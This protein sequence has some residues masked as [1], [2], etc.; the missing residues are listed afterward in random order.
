[1]IQCLN[2]GI[3]MSELINFRDFGGYP[4]KDGRK[5]KTGIFYRSGS[6]RD[7]TEEDRAYVKT[8]NIQNLHDFREP[9]ELDKDERKEGLA[10]NVHDI[11]ASLHL[12]GF[13]EDPSV[14]YT[15]L[16]SES[17]IEFYE[18]LPFS[19]PAYQNVFKVLQEEDAVPYLHNC[20]AGKDRTGVATALIQLALGMHEDAIVYD[21]MLSMEA[22]DAIFENE[23]RRL[24]EGRTVETLLYKVPGLIIKPGY[25]K[26]ALTAIIEKY[27]SY[28]TYF[29]AE[30][31]L[32]SEKLEALRERYTE[33]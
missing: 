19:N 31:G 30:Y 32:D 12:G 24:K 6:Y 25:L 13:E 4:T 16:S 28:E 2:G 11:S 1:M 17:M 18:K 29:E 26:S 20:T 27:G 21:Y 5:I 23:V 22:Y 14:P 33:R 8:L 7:L 9:T 10:K 3:A 15:V